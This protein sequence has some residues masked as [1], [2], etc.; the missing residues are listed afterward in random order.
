MI[1]EEDQA[2]LPRCCAMFLH[3]GIDKDLALGLPRSL[4]DVRLSHSHPP[5]ECHRGRV[6]VAS[7]GSVPLA[8]KL[9][10]DGIDSVLKS[11]EEADGLRLQESTNFE[12]FGDFWTGSLGWGGFG[13][14]GR[15]IWR[16]PVGE[17]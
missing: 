4:A 1:G 10:V 17:H 3:D 15:A 11:F 6:H 14:S 2:N 8:I 12:A 5:V 7:C 16:G 9:P 13:G